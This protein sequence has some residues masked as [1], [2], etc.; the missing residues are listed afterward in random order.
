MEDW[1]KSV[2][3]NVRSKK[4]EVFWEITEIDGAEVEGLLFGDV[5]RWWKIFNLQIYLE[6]LQIV[7][8]C[9][10]F[11]PNFILDYYMFILQAYAAAGTLNQNYANILLMLLRLRQACDHPLLVKG[12]TSDSV[13]RDS[14]HMA[15]NL[16]RNMLINLMKHLETSAICLSCNVS[17]PVFYPSFLM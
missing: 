15:K 3:G 17:Y 10:D 2:F 13:G 11:P 5:E 8:F 9:I 14:M 7:P 1:N 16:P 4:V 12:F 6:P